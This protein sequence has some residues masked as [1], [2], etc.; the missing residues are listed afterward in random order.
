[1]GD[2]YNNSGG[3]YFPHGVMAYGAPGLSQPGVAPDRVRDL[4][5]TQAGSAPAVFATARKVSIAARVDDDGRLWLR[6]SIDGHHV[7]EVSTDGDMLTLEE[8]L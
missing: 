4:I 1:M 7:R 2:H 8:A 3:G 6:V 5:N